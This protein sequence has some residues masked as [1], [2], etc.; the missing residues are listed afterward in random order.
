MNQPS[1]NSEAFEIYAMPVW[2]VLGNVFVETSVE[3]NLIAGVTSV[4]ARLH[5]PVT[6]VGSHVFLLFDAASTE[7]AG[8][9]EVAVPHFS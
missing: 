6:H 4:L 3:E 7:K 2:M 9:A 5:M 8:K 1:I